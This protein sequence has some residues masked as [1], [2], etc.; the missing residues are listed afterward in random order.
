MVVG[1][2]RVGDIS[3]VLPIPIFS[4][5][6][7]VWSR[8]TRGG[9]VLGR[10]DLKPS[11]I[12]HHCCRRSSLVI[13]HGLHSPWV[14]PPSSRLGRRLLLRSTNHR[15]RSLFLPLICS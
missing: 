4:I 7:L 9:W 3:S 6:V 14:L 13:G 8:E 15:C 2:W 1:G 10:R 11:S 5:L 12:R